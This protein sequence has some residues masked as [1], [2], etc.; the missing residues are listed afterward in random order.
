MVFLSLTEATQLDD[1]PLTAQQVAARLA[2]L[3]IRVGVTGS[4]R[5]RLVTHYWIDDAAVE[6]AVSAFGQVMS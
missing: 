6:R 2:E 3:G 5:F 1:E 4:Y